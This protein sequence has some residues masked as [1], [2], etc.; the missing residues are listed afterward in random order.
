MGTARGG[1]AV[2][3]SFGK[4]W[5]DHQVPP[6]IMVIRPEAGASR[7][8]VPTLGTDGSLRLDACL[9]PFGSIQGSVTDLDGEPM[10]GAVVFHDYRQLVQDLQ[11]PPIRGERAVHADMDG[12]FKIDHLLPGRYLL[13]AWGKGSA[14]AFSD[15]IEVA[16][17]GTT[18]AIIRLPPGAT[19]EGVVHD[20]AG[21]LRK[22]PPSGQR[23]TDQGGRPGQR[24]RG[25][26][27]MPGGANVALC[28]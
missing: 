22:E 19:I 18:K 1:E 12:L 23:R 2:F 11:R 5:E 13:W 25:P 24:G 20:A 4:D 7:P 27:A 6:G 10:P 14:G 16:S 8:K 21:R 3:N 15:P 28:R 26:G 9:E 17:N